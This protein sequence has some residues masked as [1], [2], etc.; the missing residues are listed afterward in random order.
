VDF[1]ATCVSLGAVFPGKSKV[2]ECV[3]PD[4]LPP[5]PK[6][7]DAAKGQSQN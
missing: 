4:F 2:Y 3:N 1:Y 5:Q 6:K 7:I